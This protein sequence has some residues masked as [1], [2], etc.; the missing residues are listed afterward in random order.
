MGKGPVGKHQ[1]NI[2]GN[3]TIG[4]IC[5]KYPSEFFDGGNWHFL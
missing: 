5:P 2:E 4:V 3:K 1:Y